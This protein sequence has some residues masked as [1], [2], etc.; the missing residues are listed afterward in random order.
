MENT[1]QVE[2][3][4]QAA[5]LAAQQVPITKTFANTRNNFVSD[6]SIVL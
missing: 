3:G 4:L 1:N 6:F 5:V 2:Q